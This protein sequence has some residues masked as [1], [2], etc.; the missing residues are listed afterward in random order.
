MKEEYN[1]YLKMLVELQPDGNERV[2][3]LVT[4]YEELREEEKALS[5]LATGISQESAIR[6]R[7]PRRR[8]TREMSEAAQ[9]GQVQP[10]VRDLMKTLLEDHPSPIGNRH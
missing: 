5:R 4:A 2:R 6:N 10:I 8:S 7:E 3:T 1:S 9:P